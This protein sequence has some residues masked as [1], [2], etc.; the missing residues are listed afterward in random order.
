MRSVSCTMFSQPIKTSDIDYATGVVLVTASVA[1][2][3][4]SALGLS[5]RL[6]GYSVGASLIGVG[7]GCPFLNFVKR[8][9]LGQETSLYK[10][11]AQIAIPLGVGAAAMVGRVSLVPVSR[12][13]ISAASLYLAK[14]VC[15]E[16]G[17]VD[18]QLF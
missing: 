10:L 8:A 7:V 6:S 4:L 5:G 13:G 11:A 2:L 9:V 12:V 15:C 17:K 18:P 16:G 1:L 3:T 14:K